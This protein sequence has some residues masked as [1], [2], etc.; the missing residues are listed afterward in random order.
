MYKW[1][2]RW[3]KDGAYQALL[4]A[5]VIHLWLTSPNEWVSISRGRLSPWMRP[6]THRTISVSSKP[7]TWNQQSIP[8]IEIPRHH[9]DC[10]DVS[11]TW[12]L[13]LSTSLQSGADLWMGR[14]LLQAR[15]ELLSPSGNPHRR[16]SAGLFDDQLP[17]DSQ[18]VLG[19]L[20]MNTF[21]KGYHLKWS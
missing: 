10:S 9:R 19:L 2:N 6:L 7:I 14:H 3:S 5:L 21:H 18:Y 4:E 8:T 13:S 11:L 15:A 16:S 17:G 20:A 12:S 1:H